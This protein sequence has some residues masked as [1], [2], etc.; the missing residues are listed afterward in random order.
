MANTRSTWARAR[1]ALRHLVR[2]KSAATPFAGSGAYWEDRYRAGKD[3]GVGSYGKFAELKAE[4]INGF[5]E[6]HGIESVIEFGCGDGHQLRLA[7]YPRYLG[8]DVSERAVETCRRVFRSDP[9]RTFLLTGDYAGQTAELSLSLDVI[10]HLVEDA[11]FESYMTTLFASAQRF[12]LIYSSNSE[13]NLG[14]PVPHVRHRKFTDWVDAR[15]GG[16]RL[17]EQIPNRYPYRGDYREG[18]FA[19]FYIFERGEEPAS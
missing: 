14:E 9:T 2:G 18:S 13:R 16:F 19:D 5:V 7:D 12:V 1:K 10:Y 15:A 17:I 11:V 3:S 8:L 6:R 4:I